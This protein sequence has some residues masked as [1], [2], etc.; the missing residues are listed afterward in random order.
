MCVVAATNDGGNDSSANTPSNMTE[1]V[2]GGFAGINK[3]LVN[4]GLI[5]TGLVH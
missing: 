2:S 3:G 1:I 4:F 5:N